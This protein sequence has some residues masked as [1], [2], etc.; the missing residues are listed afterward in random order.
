VLSQGEHEDQHDVDRHHTPRV[1]KRR[2]QQ[3]YAIET[4][5]RHLVGKQQDRIVEREGL[6]FAQLLHEF[7]EAPQGQQHADEQKQQTQSVP[8]EEGRAEARLLG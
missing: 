8:A 7:R 2:E 6:A 4:R 3:E 1:A 5:R